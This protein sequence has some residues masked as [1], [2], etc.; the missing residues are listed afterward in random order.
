VLYV[1][2]SI[3]VVFYKGWLEPSS[4]NVE[5]F[6]LKYSFNLNLGEV[7]LVVVGIIS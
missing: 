4:M 2:I 3:K 5:V 7:V 1:S 6:Q